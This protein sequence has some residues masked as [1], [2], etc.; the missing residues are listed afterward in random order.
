MTRSLPYD[1]LTAPTVLS[2]ALAAVAATTCT[3]LLFVPDVLTGPAVMNGSA[4]GTALVALVVGVPLLVAATVLTRRG[5]VRALPVW[6]GAQAY[7]LYNAVLFAFATPFDDLFVL[8]V[9]T[10]GLSLWSLVVTLGSVDVR[11]FAAM[12]GA[13]APVRAVAGYVGVV[14]GLNTL[15]WLVPV[16]RATVADGPATFLA[17]TGMTTNPVYVQDLAFWLPALGLGAVLL[18]RRAAWG[19]L[20]VT[21]GLVVLGGRGFRGGQRPVVRA[22]RRPRGRQS[23]RPRRPRRSRCSGWSA[24]CRSSPCCAG[25]RTGAGGA[26]ARPLGPSGRSLVGVQ[27]FVGLMAVL[28]GVQL[29]ANGFGMP[30]AWLARPARSRGCCPAS[31]CSS[32]SRP[33]SSCRQPLWPRLAGGRDR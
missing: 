25:C 9:A 12:V 30:T 15:A 27:A 22:R 2:V 24:W 23:P 32:R 13:D 26:A 33:R 16:L 4:R 5:F 3:L 21:A 10:L 29:I 6:L 20:I 1:R 8:I 17:G 18:W 19:Y 7:L 28:G 31:R 11:R 14:V